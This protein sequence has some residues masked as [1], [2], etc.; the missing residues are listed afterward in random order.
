MK[1]FETQ[2]RNFLGGG[3][4]IFSRSGK[5]DIE[6]DADSKVKS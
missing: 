4:S 5:N 3:K 1:N 6:S 2:G